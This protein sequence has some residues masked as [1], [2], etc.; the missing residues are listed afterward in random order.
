MELGLFANGQ[1]ITRE[2]V[3]FLKVRWKNAG[4]LISETVIPAA[5]LSASLTAQQW[6]QGNAALVGVNYS[7]GSTGG[8]P[9]G[10]LTLEVAATLT[11]GESIFASGTIESATLAGL[12]TGTPPAPIPPVAYTKEEVDALLAEQKLDLEEFVT[13]SATERIK[14]E[15]TYV[16]M[17]IFAG[18]S[19]SGGYADNSSATPEELAPQPGVQILNNSTFLFEDLDIGTNNL[20]DHAGLANGVTHGWELQLANSIRAGGDWLEDVIYLVKCGQGASLIADWDENDVYWHKLKSR[21]DTARI[22][23]AALGLKPI[24][25][26]FYSQGINDSIYSTPVATWKTA[27]KDYFTRLRQHIGYAPIMMTRLPPDR[28]D[29]TAAIN[30][31]AREYPWVFPIE[32]ADATL[33]DGNHWDYAGMKLIASRMIGNCIN[34]IGEAGTY[35]TSL[36]NIRDI[37]WT[38]E[39]PDVEIPRGSNMAYST[40][41]TPVPVVWGFHQ[42][43]VSAGNMLVNTGSAPTGARMTTQIDVTQPFVVV[44]DFPSAGAANATVV[45]IDDNADDV[46]LWNVGLTYVAGL[47][48]VSG[49][50]VQTPGGEGNSA[51]IGPI[52]PPCKARMRGTGGSDVYVDRSDDGGQN[53]YRVSTMAGVLAGKTNLYLRCLFAVPSGGQIAVTYAT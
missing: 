42:N 19:N 48:Q 43:S 16:P 32:V 20:I 52:Y 41:G 49:S 1:M 5:S 11:G 40:T 14:P 33:K 18:E 28:P 37:Q 34:N 10:M 44:L 53:W 50:L 22:A 36:R 17:I 3:T 30:E 21:V 12:V 31:I 4:S 9:A 24:P 23:L 35:L 27:T 38:V 7:A 15:L 39:D 26:V 51:T 8:L 2:D 25:Y 29:Y 6:R 47:H 13:Q 45:Y 46:F